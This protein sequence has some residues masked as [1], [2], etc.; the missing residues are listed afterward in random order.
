MCVGGRGRVDGEEEGCKKE[1]EG[2]SMCVLEDSEEESLY[3]CG[4]VDIH[5]S[6]QTPGCM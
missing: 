1:G 4:S 5:S 6:P 3:L 2:V